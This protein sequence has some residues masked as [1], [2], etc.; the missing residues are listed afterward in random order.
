M[1]VQSQEDLQYAWKQLGKEGFAQGLSRSNSA[2]DSKENQ[3]VDLRDSAYFA[4]PFSFLLGLIF[5]N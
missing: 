2:C 3:A 4:M 1:L 5:E